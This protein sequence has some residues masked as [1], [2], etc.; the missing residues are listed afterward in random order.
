[1]RPIVRA[2]TETQGAAPKTKREI[3][4]FGGICMLIGLAILGV[5][6]ISAVNTAFDLNLALGSH[7]TATPLPKTWD[8]VIGLGAA[9]VL[10]I[11]L[12]LFGS[13]VRTMY[14]DAKG[15]PALRALILVGAL[16][17]LVAAGRGIQVIALTMT[18]G[19]MLAYYCTDVGSIDDVED[20][21]E[22]AT[23]EELDACLHRTAQW[24]RADLLDVVIGAG[25]NFED[26]SSD[27]S[28]RRC[29]LDS[30]VSHEYVE[31]AIELGA[32]PSTCPNSDALIQARV[33]RANDD[34]ESAKIVAA[35]LAAGWSA[36]AVSE[37][38]QVEA[39]EL[40]KQKRLPNTLAVLQR[41][42]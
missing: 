33:S 32:S 38:D 4:I 34:D 17:L 42:P 10:L 20:R 35:L 26:S 19:S 2:V 9:G 22:G 5:T 12:T 25:A 40:A 13:R 8:A 37:H 7:G 15:K 18:Y 16:G 3:G 31:K 36:H 14:Q 1:M 11:A 39:V 30:D 21:L 23:P 29:V 41:Q 28:F 27:P 6:L 24:N